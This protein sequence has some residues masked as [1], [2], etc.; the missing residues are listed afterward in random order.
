MTGREVIGLPPRCSSGLL[1]EPL[2]HF[3]AIGGVLLGA[4][5]LLDRAPDAEDGIAEPRSC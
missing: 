2:V 5:S 4:Y 3:L 1:R